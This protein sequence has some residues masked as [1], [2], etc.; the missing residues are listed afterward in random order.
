MRP[1]LFELRGAFTTLYKN[2]TPAVWASTFRHGER[3]VPVPKL[4][5]RTYQLSRR[6]EPFAGAQKRV[7]SSRLCCGLLRREIVQCNLGC[8]PWRMLSAYPN[9]SHA[10]RPL[11]RADVLEARA[12]LGVR[13]EKG[14][15]ERA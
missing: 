14:A 4:L 5:R 15:H 8:A 13:L 10:A 3:A 6:T 9:G 12:Q 2:L 11:V 7:W 1:P